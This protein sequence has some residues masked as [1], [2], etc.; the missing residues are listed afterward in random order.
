LNTSLNMYTYVNSALINNFEVIPIKIELYCQD[1]GLPGVKIIGL[2][3]TGVRESFFRVKAAIKACGYNLPNKKILI[4]FSPADIQ[5]KGSSF[6]LALATL[7][8]KSIKI[9]RENSF[10]EHLILGELSLDGL[11][12]KVAGVLPILDYLNKKTTNKLIIPFENLNEASLISNKILAFKNLNEFIAFENTGLYKSSDE[13]LLN[14]HKISTSSFEEK[15]F[16]D[17]I[18]QPF[19]I[20]ACE[21]AAVGKHHLLMLGSPGSGKS[22][23]GERIPSIMPALSRDELIE[24]NSIYSAAGLLKNKLIFKIPYRAPHH[25]SSDASIVGGKTIG[26][27]T[28]AHNGILFLDEFSEFKYNVLNSLREPL[29]K[30]YINIARVGLNI[31]LPAKFILVA[32]SNP[33]NCGNY[34]NNNGTCTC[35]INEIL[36][37]KRK[38]NGPILDRFDLKV[39]IKN[40]NILDTKQKTRISTKDL[41]E[42]ILNAINFSK[43]I[44]KTTINNLAL[45]KLKDYNN[46]NK[47]TGRNISKTIAVAKTI[48]Y[49]ANS[50][51]IK[52]EHIYESIQYTKPIRWLENS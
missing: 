21:L 22:M 18:N 50:D 25:T 44:K 14:K 45:A 33:C 26:E 3:D 46:S 7:F 20:R 17:V 43:S 52:E 29:E 4:N 1:S 49:L 13:I 34:L 9:F 32:A 6:D 35:T 51:E 12:K 19:A 5:K 48:S 24:V 39:I 28:L 38:L 10:K 31:L 27:I 41:K 47:V 8:L 11:L 30:G 40:P 15:D 36:R 37:F 2:T 16:L 42:R 23:L